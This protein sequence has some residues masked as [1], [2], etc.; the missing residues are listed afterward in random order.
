[1]KQIGIETLFHAKAGRLPLWSLIT[2]EF[3]ETFK[4]GKQMVVVSQITASA[5]TDNDRN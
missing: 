3:D 1:M 5:S 4:G 2:R